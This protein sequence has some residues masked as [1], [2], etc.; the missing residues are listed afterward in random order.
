MDIHPTLSFDSYIGHISN[1]CYPVTRCQVIG[2]PDRAPIVSFQNEYILYI[3]YGDSKNQ[4]IIIHLRLIEIPRLLRSL[5][6]NWL[7]FLILAHL[8][9]LKI[10]PIYAF[11][12]QHLLILQRLGTHFMF[13]KSDM[14]G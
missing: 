9:W 1:L 2:N 10:T 3:C 4:Q 11:C 5:T 7:R 13:N 6:F 8:K 12:D 14:I